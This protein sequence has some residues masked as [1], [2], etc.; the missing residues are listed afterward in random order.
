MPS[1]EAR[2]CAVP[3]ES[4]ETSPV[5][6]TEAIDDVA[7]VHVTV[8]PPK[9]LPAASFATADACAVLPIEMFE[10]S[11]T[12]TDATLAGVELTLTFMLPVTP[13]ATAVIVAA[14][15]PTADTMP[16]LETVATPGFV[17]V[18]L[19]EAATVVPCASFPVAFACVV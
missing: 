18:Q 15:G 6:E 16:A 8:L 3:L 11:A 7:L 4:P 17:V 14:P 5:D 1:T 19:K 10:G 9:T 13:E 12:V 2:I